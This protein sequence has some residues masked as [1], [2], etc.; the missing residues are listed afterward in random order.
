MILSKL[1]VAAPEPCVLMV[2]N[3]C[4]VVGV[5]AVKLAVC[6]DLLWIAFE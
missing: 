6:I 1:G 5:F 4:G 3:W 2:S